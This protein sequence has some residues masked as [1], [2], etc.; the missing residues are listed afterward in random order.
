MQTKRTPLKQKI[1]ITPAG[2]DKSMP[3]RGNIV[4][5][6]KPFAKLMV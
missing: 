5:K 2:K 6:G 1:Q 3:P 4:D